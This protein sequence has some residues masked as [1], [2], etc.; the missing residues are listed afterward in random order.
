[1][2]RQPFHP[3]DPAR[4]VGAGVA[5]A[6]DRCALNAQRDVAL[7]LERAEITLDSAGANR[8]LG[9]GVTAAGSANRQKAANADRT[10][11]SILPKNDWPPPQTVHPH[12]ALAGGDIPAPAKPA[13]I[14]GPYVRS[15]ISDFAA[16][17]ILGRGLLSA[18]AAP[19]LAHSAG[20]ETGPVKVKVTE[21]D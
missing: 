7:K 17:L 16:L 18:P 10:H 11:F 15:M 9:P 1:M 3:S 12:N 13:A 6:V 20:C 5:P 4:Q 2:R 21:W 19:T 14:V 8:D